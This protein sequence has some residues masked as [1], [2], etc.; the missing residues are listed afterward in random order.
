MAVNGAIQRGR[1]IVDD[2]E[3]DRRV[4]FARQM[5]VQNQLIEHH[6]LD[7]GLF[8]AGASQH[9]SVIQKPT[10]KAGACQR[11]GELHP[12]L[13]SW[14]ATPRPVSILTICCSLVP[15]SH[16]EQPEM[17][18]TT[19]TFGDYEIMI[20]AGT[21][22]NL[23]VTCAGIGDP[24]NNRMAFEFRS[25]IQDAK[26]NSHVIYIKDLNR[27]WFNNENGIQSL[28]DFLKNYIKDNHIT[29]T[30]AFGLSA[31]GYGAFVLDHLVRFTRV[32]AMST[33][34]QLSKIADLDRRNTALIS[35]VDHIR[36]P[37]IR[38]LIREDGSYTIIVP[39][40]CAEDIIQARGLASVSNVSILCAKGP[41]NLGEY[42]RGAGL[43]PGLIKTIAKNEIFNPHSFGL[44]R[45]PP[46]VYELA[47]A[48]VTNAEQPLTTLPFD[49]RPTF[50]MISM[51][52]DEPPKIHGGSVLSGMDVGHILT[53]GWSYPEK[54]G[55]WATG[56]KHSI[57]G[58]VVDIYRYKSTMMRL[59]IMPFVSGHIVKQRCIVRV[60]GSLI[61]DK[62]YHSEQGD[63]TKEIWCKILDSEFHVEIET[64]DRVSPKSLGVSDDDRELSI[65]LSRILMLPEFGS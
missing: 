40:D 51:R 33:R 38:K 27:T 8:A 56:L 49:F 36:F 7:C 35:K 26:I 15:H 46:S 4:E 20:T 44:F 5:A 21:S 3:I 24:E 18:D 11:S 28:V 43:L 47:V 48:K 31:G 65:K 1:Q 59:S 60:N 55:I 41:H 6:H 57:R 37:E 32:V 14:L 50:N 62:D 13:S 54:S 10:A 25:A 17:T 23:L 39:L 61:S 22:D 30:C 19:K 34:S 45:L 58:S 12:L 52:N 9:D 29:Y 42:M 16:A 64:P 63:P 53:T 2:A